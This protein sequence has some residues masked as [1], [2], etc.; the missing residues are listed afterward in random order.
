MADCGDGQCKNTCMK[1]KDG[2]NFPLNIY[3][4]F[5]KDIF[6]KC[7]IC[8]RAGFCKIS[9]CKVQ[10][11]N[12][13][14]VIQSVV[15]GAKLTAR[16]DDGILNFGEKNSNGGTSLFYD[17]RRLQEIHQ[18]MHGVEKKFE[19][20]LGQSKAIHTAKPAMEAAEN[21]VKNIFK[22]PFS[23][24]NVKSINQAMRKKVSN[25]VAEDIEKAIHTFENFNKHVQEV[26]VLNSQV[27]HASKKDR[28]EYKKLLIKTK[29]N[30]E[31]KIKM[32]NKLKERSAKHPQVVRQLDDIT[33][34]LERHSKIL[35]KIHKHL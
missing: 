2:W 30:A 6:G 1:I 11:Q 23:G 28:N 10:E 16:I 18:V 17:P 14:K 27:K 19:K 31:K 20:Q 32:F 34:N 9:E 33:Q 35:G 4:P 3:E 25:N 12:E 7:E 29:K 15:N 26:S 21:V 8:F 5:L 24:E 13:L 22:E